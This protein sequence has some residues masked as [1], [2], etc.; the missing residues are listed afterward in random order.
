M[1]NE[2]GRTRLPCDATDPPDECGHV[3]GRVFVISLDSTGERVHNDEANGL[4]GFNLKQF[5]LFD[6]CCLRRRPPS[7]STS[8]DGPCSV[9]MRSG[10]AAFGSCSKPWTPGRFP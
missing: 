5:G 2:N 7:N 8:V 10:R 9:L 4:A 6:D 1:D 3:L